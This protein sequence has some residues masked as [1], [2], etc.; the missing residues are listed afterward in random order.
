MAKETC[1]SRE[2]TK[3]AVGYFTYQNG[4]SIRY[5]CHQH[6]DKA[7]IIKKFYGMKVVL[8]SIDT[9]EEKQPE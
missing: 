9:P 8:H 5:F 3:D 2:C 6:A 7:I 4:K 1:N